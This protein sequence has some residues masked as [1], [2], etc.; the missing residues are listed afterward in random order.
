MAELCADTEFAVLLKCCFRN[1]LSLSSLRDSSAVLPF[2]SATSLCASSCSASTWT[3][4]ALSRFSTPTSSR[5]SLARSSVSF[6]SCVSFE[7]PLP[8]PNKSS[9]SRSWRASSAASFASRSEVLALNALLSLSQRASICSLSFSV[10]W[11][12]LPSSWPMRSMLRCT[13]RREWPCSSAWSLIGG[14]ASLTSA[15]A[16]ETSAWN[17]WRPSS[18][19]FRSSRNPST[20]RIC[21]STLADI[22]DRSLRVLLFWVTAT[23]MSPIS[24][25]SMLAFRTVGFRR[26]RA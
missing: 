10:S 6:R 22:I 7:R 4:V 11:W 2:A 20:M 13:P 5:I 25:S 9:C 19:R 23:R 24:C 17:L 1:L 12:A 3:T 21:V 18:Q 14:I 15:S 16:C 26:S 8:S